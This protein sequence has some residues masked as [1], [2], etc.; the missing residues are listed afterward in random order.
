MLDTAHQNETRD[1]Y[2]LGDGLIGRKPDS[3]TR[4][5]AA[6]WGAAQISAQPLVPLLAAAL[7]TWA[8]RA[9]SLGFGWGLPTY[10][11]GPPKQ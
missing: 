5:A 8:L 4:T 10:R 1:A 2:E 6:A 9:G 11:H 7:V 3:N